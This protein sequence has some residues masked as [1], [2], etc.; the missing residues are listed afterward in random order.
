[1]DDAQ[2]TLE[3]ELLETEHVAQGCERWVGRVGFS[4]SDA[5]G[6][7]VSR[8]IALWDGDVDTLPYLTLPLLRFIR[9]SGLAQAHDVRH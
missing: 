7:F 8:V 1:M 5:L 4:R 2:S 3:D 6:S 9:E